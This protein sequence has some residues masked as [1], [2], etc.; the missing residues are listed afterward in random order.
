MQVPRFETGQ[1]SSDI[2]KQFSSVPGIDP[3]VLRKLFDQS[4]MDS[5][6]V[7]YEWF[8]YTLAQFWHTYSEW[9]DE[10][11]RMLIEQGIGDMGFLTLHECTLGKVIARAHSICLSSTFLYLVFH[12]STSE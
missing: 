10:Y 4:Q 1:R 12:G 2:R 7:E 8:N 6:N 11:T 9:M 5:I 3:S